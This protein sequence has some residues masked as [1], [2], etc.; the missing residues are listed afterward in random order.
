ML[1]EQIVAKDLLYI[2]AVFVLFMGLMGLYF[3]LSL[4][5]IEGKEPSSCPQCQSTSFMSNVLGKNVCRRCGF[6]S[7]Q[8]EEG[9][10]ETC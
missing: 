3:L 2:G 9:D 10:N 7:G 8:E 4:R 1:S 5:K 6:L